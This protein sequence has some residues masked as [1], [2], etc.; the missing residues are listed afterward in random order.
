M[1]SHIALCPSL[2]FQENNSREREYSVKYR[3]NKRKVS[4]RLKS[5]IRPTFACHFKDDGNEKKNMPNKTKKNHIVSYFSKCFRG[6]SFNIWLIRCRE[7]F[8][9]S[10]GIFKINKTFISKCTQI[11]K[12]LKQFN[13]WCHFGPSQNLKLNRISY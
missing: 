1:L 9:K 5:L 10:R 3:H 11:S 6:I 12:N 7:L 2:K 8:S 13:Y 4:T